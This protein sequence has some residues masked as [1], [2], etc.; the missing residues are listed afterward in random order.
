M[1]T[2]I[3]LVAV[4]GCGLAGCSFDAGNTGIDATVPQRAQPLVDRVVLRGTVDPGLV[5]AVVTIDGTVVPTSGGAWTHTVALPSGGGSV[6]LAVTLGGTVLE[7]REI[8][9]S[10]P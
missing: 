9:V 5:G 3:V 2:L 6:V 7:R 4:L 8:S 10:T 1:R